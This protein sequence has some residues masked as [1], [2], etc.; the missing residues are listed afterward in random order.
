ML[1]LT[2]VLVLDDSHPHKETEGGDGSEEV[3]TKDVEPS[4]EASNVDQ[5]AGDASSASQEEGRDVEKEKE[6]VTS[7]L[8]MGLGMVA[9]DYSRLQANAREILCLSSPVRRTLFGGVSA[10]P[11]TP[12]NHSTPQVPPPLEHSRSGLSTDGKFGFIF[13]F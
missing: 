11:S 13:F 3:P 4:K 5:E 9:A 8:A 7:G 2:C 10:T 1:Y 6:Q 12:L